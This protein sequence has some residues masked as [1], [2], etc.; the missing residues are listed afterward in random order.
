MSAPPLSE[1][2]P[3]SVGASFYNPTHAT[4]TPYE[5]TPETAED[6]VL[7]LNNDSTLGLGGSARLDSNF[8]IPADS[9][10]NAFDSAKDFQEPSYI[11]EDGRFSLLRGKICGSG[12]L[13]LA[14]LREMYTTFRDMATNSSG[15]STT[16]SQGT[17]RLLHV[18]SRAVIQYVGELQ[19]NNNQL[20]LS[21]ARLQATQGSGQTKEQQM[22]GK[23]TIYCHC[24]PGLTPKAHIDVLQGEIESVKVKI[25]KLRRDMREVEA[26][27]DNLK[28]DLERLGAGVDLDSSIEGLSK[29]R[30]RQ[31]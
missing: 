1:A 5:T 25:D 29:K 17:L 19:A 22:K 11:G 4:Y 21:N 28:A 7:P 8:E 9:V 6:M 13:N 24:I 30:H 15:A 27:N 23:L 16:I 2:E 18:M 26:Q 20:Q 12:A 14:N 3:I 31:G 10:S